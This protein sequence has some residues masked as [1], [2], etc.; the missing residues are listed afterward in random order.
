MQVSEILLETRAEAEHVKAQL[1]H[2]SFEKLAQ[3]YTVRP[4]ARATKGNLG[5]LPVDELGPFSDAL[6]EVP[7]GQVVG[8]L[9]TQGYYALLKVG[10]RREARPMTF[11]EAE[12]QIMEML[13][14]RFT[15]NHQRAVYEGLQDR[16]DID[17]DTKLL[18]SLPL[19]HENDI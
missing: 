12:D 15:K 2:T 7:S 3:A 14:L 9:E 18:Y 19:T 10:E 11:A 5:F 1:A 4:A 6:S 13:R 17:V 8:P 16:Y